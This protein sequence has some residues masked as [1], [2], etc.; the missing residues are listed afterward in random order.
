MLHNDYKIQSTPTLVWS[1]TLHT[2]SSIPMTAETM[3]AVLLQASYAFSSL[4]LLVGGRKGI[5][6]VKN[7][8]VGCWHGYLS[9]AICRVVYGPADATATH[10]LCFSK[11]QI[12]FTFPVPDHLGSRGQRAVKCECVRVCVCSSYFIWRQCRELQRLLPN[13]NALVA[14]SKVSKGMRAVAPTKSSSS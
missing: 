5:R 11:I 1:L 13:P 14:V 3:P 10:C 7:W 8:V 6:P 9:G 12:G 2:F 4:T